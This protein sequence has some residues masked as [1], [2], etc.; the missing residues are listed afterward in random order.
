[1]EYPECRKGI[2][3]SRRG[4]WCGFC[5]LRICPVLVLCIPHSL[6]VTTRMAYHSESWLHSSKSIQIHHLR[7][8]WNV[9]S[10]T[11]RAHVWSLHHKNCTSI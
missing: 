7:W 2:V 8:S 1:M 10:G 4:V 11:T 6:R 3:L 5:L 9:S